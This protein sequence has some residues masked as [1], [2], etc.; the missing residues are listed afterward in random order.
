M[1]I[2][3]AGKLIVFRRE[4]IDRFIHGEEFFIGDSD[5]LVCRAE[6][7][8]HQ[9][10]L[11]IRLANLFDGTLMLESVGVKLG[12]GR[13]DSIVILSQEDIDVSALF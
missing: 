1:L 8:L 13:L 2:D 11:G 4:G 5:N 10:I 12:F 7:F 9:G 6:L 3:P